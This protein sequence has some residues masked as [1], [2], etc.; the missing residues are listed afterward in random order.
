MNFLMIIF[1]TVFLNADYLYHDNCVYDISDNCYTYSSDNSRICDQ[2]III[3]DFIGGYKYAD[4]NCTKD[5][6]FNQIGLTQHEWNFQMALMG[7]LIGF[8]T[9]FL[10]LFL[11]V[12]WG[13]K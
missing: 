12:L 6:I 9:L 8:T 1:F 4:G 3:E 5:E 13:R 10:T 7:N 2:D 11:T